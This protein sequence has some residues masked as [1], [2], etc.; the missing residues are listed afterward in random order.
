[1]RGVVEVLA[2][3]RAI[4]D[5]GRLTLYLIIS[6]S[7]F[8][9]LII[10]LH[11]NASA[12]KISDNNKLALFVIFAC[13]A[14]ITIPLLLDIILDF[15]SM[16]KIPYLHHRLLSTL[17]FG[18]SNAVVL[19]YLFSPHGEEILMTLS[20]WSYFLEFAIIISSL[21][22]LLG[23]QRTCLSVVRMILAYGGIYAFFLGGLLN[24][25]TEAG[26]ILTAIIALA[27]LTVSTLMALSL[28]Y[29][30]LRSHY[31]S[32][33]SSGESILEWYSNA[34]GSTVFVQLRLIGKCCQLVALYI[35][36]FIFRPVY[37]FST[38]IFYEGNILPLMVIRV[39]FYVFEYL[40]ASRIFRRQMI[41]EHHDLG[42]KTKLIKYFSHEVRSP[43]MVIL[44]G[45]DLIQ[46][47][48]TKIK[49]SGCTAWD[50]TIE[51]NIADIRRSCKQS[52]E[53]LDNMILY[54]T[55]VKD[56]LKLEF[57]ARL[58]L[59]AVREALLTHASAARSYQ[60]G[61]SLYYLQEQFTNDSSTLHLN[62][63]HLRHVLEPVLSS[64]FKS[65]A[66]GPGAEPSYTN[67][68]VET[69]DHWVNECI[70]AGSTNSAHVRLFVDR[71]LDLLQSV[72]KIQLM[73][74]NASPFP[75][76]SS[77]SRLL[78][79]WLHVNLT[80][81]KDAISDTDIHMMHSHGFDFIREG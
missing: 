21:Q 11:V 54:D 24:T 2:L 6:I 48:I 10:P 5:P 73:M 45:T 77:R 53:I 20:T 28:L 17:I 37:D 66:V 58:P 80:L 50:S 26:G 78:P 22:D 31:R 9:P 64:L 35:V 19:A 63:T 59:Q 38:S 65:A 3:I 61:I 36:L 39:S 43:L 79:S 25:T 57:I 13:A 16:R 62:M 15:I 41:Q 27:G 69:A 49:A 56:S 46:Q 47:S 74:R 8:L 40:V 81:T 44:F 67:N 71:D 18:V 4:L 33:K 70:V 52:L 68:L 42:F 72:R 14:S 12:L 30:V 34:P 76:I 51:D 7:F 75:S 32:F 23:V 55:I 1:M 60:V 29:S